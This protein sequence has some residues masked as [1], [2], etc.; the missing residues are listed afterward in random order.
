MMKI[1][2][3]KIPP[4]FVFLVTMGMV[5]VCYRWLGWAN[6]ILP[7]FRELV[8]PLCIVFAGYFGLSALFEFYKAKTTVNPVSPESACQ[9]VNSGVYRFSRNPMY[10]GLLLILIGGAYWLGNLISLLCI[11]GFIFYMNQFQIIPEEQALENN[12]GEPYLAYKKTVR[13]WI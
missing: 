1:L 8:A 9:F 4:V 5:V 12:F 6:V 3:L 7:P 11:W 10:L 2:A 13:R